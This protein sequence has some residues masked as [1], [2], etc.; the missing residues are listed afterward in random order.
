MPLKIDWLKYIIS[1]SIPF[2]RL[3]FGI[4]AEDKIVHPKNTTIYLVKAITTKIQPCIVS[5]QLKLILKWDFVQ[6][7]RF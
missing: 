4:F 7:N 3:Y 6:I 2:E 5:L 1:H